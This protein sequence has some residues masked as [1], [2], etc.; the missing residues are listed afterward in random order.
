MQKLILLALALTLLFG[1][2][3]WAGPWSQVAP[4]NH[5]RNKC[6]AVVLD[7]KI[8]VIGGVD[9]DKNLAP[10]EVYDPKT[11]TWTVLGDSPENAASVPIVAAVNG[12]IYV[13]AGRTLD[14]VRPLEGFMWSP[15]DGA[16]EWQPVPDG[17]TWG[18]GDAAGAVIGSKIYL[19]SGEDDTLSD[20]LLDYVQAVDVFDTAT[21]TWSTAAPITP[22]QR[23]D[24]DA[25]AVGDKIVAIGGQGGETGAD[26]RWLDLYDA[27]TDTW[28]HFNDAVPL[29]GGWEHPRLVAIGNSVYAL[30]G[31]GEGGYSNYRLDLPDLS[32]TAL[33]PLPVPIFEG[34]AVA[35]DGRIYYMGGTDIDGNILN[36][37]YV[38]DP[39][40]DPENK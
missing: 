17:M 14:K 13:L 25:T 15:A 5:A 6:R 33:T 38:Y 24:F 21:M 19:I 4:M 40:Q 1:A 27:K 22:H 30:S 29:E 18:H 12:T 39:A 34:A 2:V 31:K 36:T 3:V 28:Q 20:E 16:P 11:D 7:G 8:Y 10:V 9:A 37:V 26:V 23:E 32:W 35:M